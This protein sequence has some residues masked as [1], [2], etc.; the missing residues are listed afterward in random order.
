MRN[1]TIDISVIVTVYNK[2][3]AVKKCFDSI[4]SNNTENV[5]IIVVNDRSTDKSMDIVKEY[6]STHN[7]IKIVTNEKNM[8]CGYSRYIGIKNA[9]K[10]WISF[11]DADDYISDD[12]F[13]NFINYLKTDNECDFI[14]SYVEAVSRRRV[15]RSKYDD[16]NLHIFYPN[17][18]LSKYD[19][20]TLHF[21][22]PSMVKRELFDK[23][24][25]CQSRMMEDM[26]TAL[27]LLSVAKKYVRIP[28]RN[29]YY[30][31]DNSGIAASFDYVKKTIYLYDN[32]AS[33]LKEIKQISPDKF[34]EYY[35]FIKEKVNEIKPIFDRMN[36]FEIEKY[37]DKIEH[38]K[39]YFLQ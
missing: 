33:S 34:K 28:G 22:N 21:L 3:N 35:E 16:G 38:I 23:V 25:Y 36:K 15:V 17:E 27:M 14:S 1:N 20:Y 10:E 32:Y 13:Q 6:T 2:E 4:F 12:Y 11:I 24:D 29:Y 18:F 39:S 5:E 37:S 30:C 31:L 8:G 26:P 19:D 9:T 7:N